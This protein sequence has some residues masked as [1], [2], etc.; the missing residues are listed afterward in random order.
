MKIDGRKFQAVSSLRKHLSVEQLKRQQAKLEKHIA[1]YLAQLDAGD[2]EKTQEAIDRSV[3]KQALRQLQDRHA[4]NL[5]V[6]AL[7][8]AQGLEQFVQGEADAKKMSR[9]GNSACVAYNVQTAVDA[10]HCLILHHAV[11]NDAPTIS[12][13]SRWPKPPRRLC[14]KSS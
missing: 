13:L 12:S 2:A 4:D 9:S 7:M 10:E 1:Q 3:V 11:T 14:S 8:E 6:Q 5:S